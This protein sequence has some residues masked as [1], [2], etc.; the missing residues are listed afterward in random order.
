MSSSHAER[1]KQRIFFNVVVGWGSYLIFIISGFILPRLMDEYLGKELLG[2]WDFSWSIVNYIAISNVGLGAQ[3]SRFISEYVSLERKDLVAESISTSFLLQLAV[4]AF[5]VGATLFIS[6]NIDFV[7][8][9]NLE[10][11]YTAKY[12]ILFLGLSLAVQMLFDTSKGVLMGHHRWDINSGVNAGSRVL[13]M[14]LMIIAMFNGH[15]LIGISVAYFTGVT[16]S[17]LVRLYFSFREVDAKIIV[18]KFNSRIAKKMF[19][20]GVKGLTIALPQLILIQTANILVGYSMGASSLAEFARPLAL[21]KFLQSFINRYSFVLT[22]IASAMTKQKD[23]T[24]IYDLVMSSA[25]WGYSLT[26]PAIVF[27]V[28]SGDT[29]IRVWM[30]EDYVQSDLLLILAVGHMLLIA[31]EPTLRVLMGLNRHGKYAIYNTI[32]VL[33]S[34]AFLLVLTVN[35]EISLTTIATAL[36]IPLTIGYGIF[37]PIYTCK[38]LNI[39][40][41]DFFK[42]AFLLPVIIGAIFFI[43]LKVLNRNFMNDYA[44]IAADIFIGGVV[45]LLLY[46]VFLLDK[47]AKQ[48]IVKKITRQAG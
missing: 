42:S 28:V 18:S 1:G 40:I 12:T 32:L 11:I 6:S 45:I 23:S 24:E 30:G 2:V 39:K 25:R 5:V 22:P 38:V 4:T 17:E 47:D 16:I 26:I 19:L 34:Y 10:L 21:I 44:I 15:G 8:K 3:T 9:E 31:N 29:L 43:V 33:L 27:F 35:Y 14:L 46:W 41:Y 13:S 37:Q 48:K 7:F 20:Y 36:C